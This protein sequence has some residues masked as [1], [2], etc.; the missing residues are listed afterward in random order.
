VGTSVSTLSSYSKDNVDTIV[1]EKV[2]TEG[3]NSVKVVD[4]VENTNPNTGIG[5]VTG[6]ANVFTTFNGLKNVFVLKGQNLN[7]NDVMPNYITGPRTYIIENG[8]LIID[9][10]IVYADNIGFVV[11]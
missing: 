10:N 7:I 6:I 2:K 9:K 4:K 3:E 5:T 1:K 8:D 11:K